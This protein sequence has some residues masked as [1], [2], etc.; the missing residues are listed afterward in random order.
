MTLSDERHLDL[1]AAKDCIIAAADWAEAAITGFG[2][3]ADLA[4]AA[5]LCVE[6]AV[7]NIVR[8]AYE[9]E[10]TARPLSLSASVF[11]GQAM[12]IVEDKGRPFD[13]L[14]AEIPARE[15]HILDA[16]I[17]GRG[18]RLMRAFTSGMTYE[19]LGDHNRLMMAFG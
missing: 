12:I 17:G 19:R 9:E 5:R 4:F 10:A 16:T 2:L 1:S 13:P 6:E 14:T 8:Y 15:G 18:L 3:N 7:T 11:G